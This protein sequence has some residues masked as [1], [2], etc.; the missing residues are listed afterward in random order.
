[1]RSRQPAGGVGVPEG[2]FQAERLER[3]TDP[4]SPEPS[5]AYQSARR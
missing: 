3:Q 4:Q 2:R 5:S 1:M